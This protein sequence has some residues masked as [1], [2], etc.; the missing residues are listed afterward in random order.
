[1][2][3]TPTESVTKIIDRKIPFF[4]NIVS[5]AIQTNCLP[6]RATKCL[7]PVH[8]IRQ[9]HGQECSYKCIELW[10]ISNIQYKF[11]S[12]LIGNNNIELGH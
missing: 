4:H 3:H 11:V 8:K 5:V 7:V 10:G 9:V 1:M 6:N 2:S 12:K